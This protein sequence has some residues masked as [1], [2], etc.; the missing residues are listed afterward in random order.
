MKR[1]LLATDLSLRCDRALH[2]ALA[3]AETPDAELTI[4]HVVG[5]EPGEP[6]YGAALRFARDTLAEQVEAARPGATR[7]KNVHTVVNH[8]RVFAEI[9]RIAHEVG[10]DLVLMGYQRNEPFQEL[11]LGSTIDRVLKVGTVPVLMVKRGSTRP[12]RRVLAGVDFS[13]PSRRAVESAMEMAA[14][15]AEIRLIHAYEVVLP[16]MAGSIGSGSHE[17]FQ[18]AFEREARHNLDAFISRLPPDS[19]FTSE[20]HEGPAVATLL[21]KAEGMQADLVAIGTHGRGWLQSVFLGNTAAKLVRQLS[22]D[23]LAARSLVAQT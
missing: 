15:N 22:C 2:R 4:M 14:A 13:S 9:V 7:L 11:F 5:S 19:R 1:F 3:L 20:V 18:E 23:V 8:G 10:V 16:A 12:Y 6:G 21:A 17:S